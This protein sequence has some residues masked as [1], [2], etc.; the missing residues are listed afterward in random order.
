MNGKPCPD[1]RWTVYLMTGRPIL[2]LRCEDCRNWFHANIRV[3]QREPAIIGMGWKFEATFNHAYSKDDLNS[4]FRCDCLAKQVYLAHNVR[5][6]LCYGHRNYEVARESPRH[7]VHVRAN[8]TLHEFLLRLTHS[9]YKKSALPAYTL[10]RRCGAVP[11]YLDRYLELMTEA[12]TMRTLEYREKRR[13]IR[14]ALNAR[15]DDATGS[16]SSTDHE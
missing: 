12:Q 15:Q 13:K 4:I 7:V 10:Q 2:L 9:A 1:C 14:E 6:D 8:D 5:C 3:V 16:A 11:E